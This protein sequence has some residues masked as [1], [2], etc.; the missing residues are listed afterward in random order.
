MY[1]IL[2]LGFLMLT[3]L[4]SAQELLTKQKAV[5]VALENNYTI[6]VVENNVEVAK[7][8][9]SKLNN[10][11]LPTLGLNAGTNM[12]RAT[13]DNGLA[14]GGSMTNV[15]D[16][17]TAANASLGVN[18]TLFNGFARKYNYKQ[19]QENYKL[20]DLQAQFV[21]ENE[22]MSLFSVYY[23]IARLT[24]DE[25]NQAQTLGIS[26]N[27]LKRTRYASEYGQNV[28]LDVLNA[29][30]DYNN[31]SISYLNIVQQL[32]NA[33]RNLNVLM[34]QPISSDYN[35]E[36][37][38]EFKQGL[39]LALL[40]KQALA[41]NV[42]ILQGE[43]ALK[44]AELN[45]LVNRSGYLPTVNFNANY[46]YNFS[47]RDN[48]FGGTAITDSKSH[49][50]QAGVTLSWNLFDGGR[51]YTRAQNA[52]IAI[53]NEKIANERTQQQL[54]RNVTNA[55]GTYSNAMFRLEAEKKNL[56]TNE[57]NFSRSTE[58]FSLGQITTIE[59]RTAQLNLLR[60]KR[61]YGNA[62]FDAKISELQ[63]LQLSGGL[64]ETAF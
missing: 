26:R 31:D 24:M 28:Q 4:V 43:V 49:G 8:N 12:S 52:K 38:I 19:F 29:E 27:R 32:E 25:S 10:G 60:A 59:F 13:V 57:L 1:K 33:K 34:G 14:S 15:F 51:T 35:I 47:D 3:S 46:G 22:L 55:W 42:S 7:N 64:L 5:E 53:E 62:Q 20:S 37:A 6:L 23:D 61:N 45:R 54:E 30:V 16:A 18:Y 41:Y 58:R 9:A 21:I 56:Q 63:L 17:I 48:F 2:I 39:S 11:Y 40:L 50:P 44:S 36:T